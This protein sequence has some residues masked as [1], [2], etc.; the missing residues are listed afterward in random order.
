MEQINRKYLTKL[1]LPCSIGDMQAA[2]FNSPHFRDIYLALGMNKMPSKARTA[3][4]LESDLMN[5]VYMRNSTGESEPVLC[6]PASKTDIFLELFHSSI[7]GGHMGMSKCVL[8]LQQKFYCPNLAYHVRT[9]MISCHVCQT[10]KN[11]KRFDRPMNRRIIDINAPTLTYLSM[12]IK[13]YA[14]L[15]G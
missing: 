8:T 2:Y 5:A 10:F 6:V 4:K 9:Y 3:K 12:D 14:T 1:Q 15:Q 13:T 7:L 11:H